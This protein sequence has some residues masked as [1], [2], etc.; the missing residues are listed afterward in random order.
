MRRIHDPERIGPVGTPVIADCKKYIIFFSLVLS[1]GIPY[2][3]QTS[4]RRNFHPGNSLECPILNPM[5]RFRPAE[6]NRS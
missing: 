6:G 2:G 4:L 3:E 5:F 1:A